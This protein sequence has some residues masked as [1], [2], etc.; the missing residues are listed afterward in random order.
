MRLFCFLAILLFLTA[1]ARAQDQSVP[2]ALGISLNRTDAHV[3]GEPVLLSLHLTNLS[4]QVLNLQ[5]DPSLEAD[6]RIQVR[7]PM[8]RSWTDVK[9]PLPGVTPPRSAFDLLPYQSRTFTTMLL[10]DRQN[11]NVPARGWPKLVFDEE[12]WF[13]IH[14][15]LSVNVNASMRA[16][17]EGD[18]DVEVKAPLQNSP[19]DLI[20]GTLLLKRDDQNRL[21]FQKN[22][23]ES[24]QG[25]EAIDTESRQFFERAVKEFP[26]NRYTPFFVYL[27]GR[28]YNPTIAGERPLAIA[29]FERLMN[30][31]PDF[32]LT[33][34]AIEN[35][36]EIY[37]QAGQ[38]DRAYALV[39]GLLNDPVTP[40]LSSLRLGNKYVTPGMDYSPQFW[41]LKR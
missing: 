37:D 19:E 20:L 17:L 38:S 31:F 28:S 29:H 32:P 24:Y 15:Q 36:A 6:L 26:V 1:T 14:V 35:L 9:N 22:Q 7:T 4:N 21:I 23:M 8:T 41:M 40:G 2:L 13:R 27:L 11:R 16:M 12:S 25:L 3:V 18:L 33:R 30:E 5:T 34:R 39:Q 10:Y